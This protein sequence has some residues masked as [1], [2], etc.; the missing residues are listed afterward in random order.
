MVAQLL[1]RTIK[2]YV[3]VVL[4]FAIN[5]SANLSEDEQIFQ[6]ASKSFLQNDFQ[7][8]QLYLEI[9]LSNY[10]NSTK[11]KETILLLE[12]VYLRSNQNE[13][14]ITLFE[15]HGD[16]T[17]YLQTFWFGQAHYN[18]GNFEKAKSIFR[19]L[20]KVENYHL[21]VALMK[22]LITVNQGNENINTLLQLETQFPKNNVYFSQ[23]M[24]SIARFY[25][26]NNNFENAKNY[27]E[28]YLIL[29][30]KFNTHIYGEVAQMHLYFDKPI[31]LA[32]LH[33]N[34]HYRGIKFAKAFI[35]DQKYRE[36][37]NDEERESFYDLKYH[38]KKNL[39]EE[40]QN[41]TLK[42]PFLYFYLAELSVEIEA[43][44]LAKTLQYY[45]YI[46]EISPNF[47]YADAVIY[48][49]GYFSF[50]V[51]TNQ[52]NLARIENIELAMNWPDSLRFTE[53]DLQE[54]INAYEK[55]YHNFPN[56]EY[57]SEAVCRL[58]IVYF[59]LALDA[60]KSLPFYQKAIEYFNIIVEKKE[61][62][63]YNF[64]LFQRGWTR[65]VSGEFESTI[66]DFSKI[67][68]ILNYN[69]S[70]KVFF[71]EDAI[72]NL[73]FSLIEYDKDFDLVSLAAKKAKYLFT[74][75]L[76]QKY[77]KPI[78]E[79]AIKLKL[80][81]SAP[82]QA[83]DLYNTFIELYPTDIDCPVF[84]DSIISIYQKSPS[85]IRENK[86]PE[87]IIIQQIERIVKDYCSDSKWYLTNQNKEISQQLKTI[88][89]AF[90]FLEKRYFNNFV[91]LSNE[92]NYFIYKNLVLNY[93]D[94][95]H[96]RKNISKN[97]K[98]RTNVIDLSMNLAD[99]FQIPSLYH[100]AI[101]NLNEFNSLFPENEL[102][103]D[104]EENIF[105][106]HEKSYY[107]Q[108]NNAKNAS[109]KNEIEMEY[110]GA[111]YAFE[112]V[113]YAPEFWGK[114]K[115]AE[116]INLIWKRAEL[117]YEREDFAFAFDD[118]FHLIELKI[119][120]K[121]KKHCYARMAEIAQMELDFPLAAEYFSEAAKFATD[122]KKK[123]FWQNELA[124]LK[125]GAEMLF[126]NGEFA[127]SAQEYLN[128][129]E[130]F[131]DNKRK[132]SAIIKAIES[133]KKAEEFEEAIILLLELAEKY[134]EKI[135]IL[136]AYSNAWTICDSLQNWEISEKL[137]NDFILKFPHSNEAYKLKLQLAD[138]YENEPFHK[139]NTAA[140][141]YLDIY[142]SADSLDIG[143][144]KRENI[145]LQ[146]IKIYQDI[147]YFDKE[148]ELIL[149]FQKLHPN[150]PNIDDLL[151]RIAIIYADK[152]DIEMMICF[153]DSF[154]KHSATNEI[155]NQVATH[156]N[157]QK[158]I[159]AMLN[160]EKKYAKHP[161][162]IELL[163]SVISIYQEKN[164]I[165]KIEG[166]AIYI[167]KK[168]PEYDVLSQI[169]IKNLNKV[170]NKIDSLFV[171]KSY[172]QMFAK[173]DTFNIIN[174][175]YQKIGL[176]LQLSS[177]Y[178][179]FAYYKKYIKFY[180]DFEQEIVQIEENLEKSADQFLKVNSATK[181][182]NHLDG[183]KGR[184]ANL[185][186]RAEET[187]KKI[188]ALITEGNQYDLPTNLRTKM[189][190][191]TAKQ[192]DYFSDVVNVQ[193]QKFIDISEQLNSEKM[194]NN[195]VKQEKY[196]KRIWAIKRD[197][198]LPFLKKAAEIY[199]TI[200]ITFYDDK[201]YTDEW[202]EQ[203]L[204]RL[205]EWKVRSPKTYVTIGADSSWTIIKNDSLWNFTTNF[206]SKIKAE[207]INFQFSEK[208]KNIFLNDNLITKN[209][210]WKDTIFTLD[211]FKF[212]QKDEN[213]VTFE[214]L[215]DSNFSTKMTLQFDQE[216][217][218]Y[219]NSIL[220]KTIFS[221]SSWFAFIGSKPDSIN[222]ADSIWTKCGEANFSF[223]Q[224]QMYGFENSDAKSI[225]HSKIDTTKIQT[226][227]FAKPFIIE[228][229]VVQADL[230]F[231]A[232]NSASIWIDGEKIVD[233]QKLISD[234]TLNKVMSQNLS[235]STIN[236]G[237]IVVEIVGDV[238][239]KGFIFELNYVEKIDDR[240]E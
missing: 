33:N 111:C 150:D 114:N 53:N 105:Y 87:E 21:R 25:Q 174:E 169:V 69:D 101:A 38:Y 120:D 156:F 140:Q 78:F 95:P 57:F 76:S 152:N 80:K 45:R 110:I 240:Q 228:N 82:M 59:T 238:K 84:V 173:I 41:H 132:N 49:V 122:V 165:N 31:I 176:N 216:K 218:A 27:Y 54:T 204:T 66:E 208:P 233:S 85:R 232:Q 226:I 19:T 159:N 193:I 134:T 145:F 222:L 34:H 23:L 12:E 123:T 89:N 214:V 154:P 167:F 155:L 74:H 109:H 202:T 210:V 8:T 65:F 73:A 72:E 62:P 161:A 235:L 127:T 190:C 39:Y 92:E 172:L 40:L 1:K 55:I 16:E 157:E 97:L 206:D 70:Q 20:E 175:K 11:L 185:M 192:Y 22:A 194:K 18:L 227:C 178:E 133:Y 186:M 231:I 9:I 130:K 48:N 58:G 153:A 3:I 75:I 17:D 79:N 224:N 217:L 220:E 163:K 144:D 63:L 112:D 91:T 200:L 117:R 35:L 212:L 30:D 191:L 96:F 36:L 103:F 128:L 6:N 162:G 198:T 107:L 207:K 170:K 116:L 203:A 14:F 7:K 29:E 119:D 225:W 28:K 137:R 26:L 46:L 90:D 67:L 211:Y 237:F 64:A 181:W 230:K 239:F 180:D 136:S 13:L 43:E 146:A 188:I 215:A 121:F 10:P 151:N 179:T 99:K 201:N 56:S 187:K 106:C 98:W 61:D 164:D 100:E 139:K 177:V 5:L 221:D 2:F 196:K 209:A 143:E 197:R 129:A 32:N 234:N 213:I 229:N 15:N 115:N 166:L 60:Q 189:L 118:Y 42:D 52:R 93:F 71:L 199:Q 50:E 236:N 86:Q 183:K 195:P 205:I 135:E 142:N 24:L 158:D 149:L 182:K 223:Y 113:L 171:E 37:N 83:I 168:Y 184:I 147:K 131:N 124:C 141:M 94:F 104:Y 88:E 138:F 108:K 160:F 77:S 81:Y 4:F 68:K 51:N 102:F 44:N 125:L 47:I 219:A 126:E 148:V